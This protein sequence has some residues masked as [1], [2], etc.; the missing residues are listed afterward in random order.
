MLI[1]KWMLKIVCINEMNEMTLKPHH[2]LEE[3]WADGRI[4][5]I[6]KKEKD[7]NKEVYEKGMYINGYNG[8]MIKEADGVEWW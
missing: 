5:E 1:E 2:I 8:W 3:K 4:N 6:M 7:K